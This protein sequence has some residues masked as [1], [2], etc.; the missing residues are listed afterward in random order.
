MAREPVLSGS[1]SSASGVSC[2][3]ETIAELDLEPLSGPPRRLCGREYGVV[4]SNARF[5]HLCFPQSFDDP[6]QLTHFWTGT[7][8]SLQVLH[9][10]GMPAGKGPGISAARIKG[11]QSRIANAFKKDQHKQYKIQVNLCIKF[12]SL[13]FFCGWE[14]ELI[15]RNNSGRF[16]G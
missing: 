13:S 2:S 14:I 16:C 10:P 3:I 6:F 8:G 1:S 5:E 9:T 12:N 4:D 15:I 11:I 7:P